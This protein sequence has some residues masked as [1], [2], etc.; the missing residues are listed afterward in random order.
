MKDEQ[1]LKATI[2]QYGDTVKRICVLYLKNNADTEDIFQNVFFKYYKSSVNFESEDHKK[3]FLIRV[4]I[5]ECK[6]FLKSFYRK[7]VVSMESINEISMEQEFNENAYVRQA[8]LQLPDKYKTVIYLHYFEG[9]TAI[10]I[11][12]IIRKKVNT[13]YTL[14]ARGREMLRTT[15]GGA[16]DE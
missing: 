6:D 11:G 14:L 4:T 5:N 10:E 16:L 2:D 3:A 8:V 1:D 7:H 13:V 9:Y 12:K 15:L